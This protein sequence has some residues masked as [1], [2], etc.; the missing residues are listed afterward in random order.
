MSTIFSI[1]KQ[2]FLPEKHSPTVL[3]SRRSLYPVKREMNFM[4]H[5]EDPQFSNP[6]ICRFYFKVSVER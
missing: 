3:K 2:S 4:S 1:F 6:N 5:V